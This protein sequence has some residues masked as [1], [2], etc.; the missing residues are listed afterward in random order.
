MSKID[1][2]TVRLPVPFTSNREIEP[3][4]RYLDRFN[5][6]MHT[7]V[8]RL[9]NQEFTK[10]SIATGDT[11]HTTS[12]YER[13]VCQNTGSLV[14]T[15]NT[16]PLDGE[17]VKVKRRDGPVQIIGTIDGVTNLTLAALDGVALEFTTE[18]SDWTIFYN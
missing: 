6:V 3:W 16:N 11:T 8:Q 1:P 12:G 15:L 5:Q 14:I 18:T 4:A 7:V 2:F 10:I 17:I 9:S 13:V